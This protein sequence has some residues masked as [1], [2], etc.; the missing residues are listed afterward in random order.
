MKYI[1]S[2]R[3]NLLSC[4]QYRFNTISNIFLW[5]LSLFATF[6]F[7]IFAFREK[8]VINNYQLKD[9]LTFIILTKIVGTFTFHFIC[10]ELG[11]N[12]KSGKLSS[13]LVMPQNTFFYLYSRTA[14]AKIVEFGLA[15]FVFALFTPVLKNYF[16]LQSQPVYWLLFL[17]SILISS[18]LSFLVGILIGILAF[19]MQEIFAVIWSVLVLINFLSGQFIPLDFFPGR[20]ANVVEYL[21][22]AAFGYFPAKVFL[23]QVSINKILLHFMVYFIWALIIVLLIYILWRRG[24][25]KYEAVGA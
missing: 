2:V 8:S 11:D 17:L 19:W 7:W 16:I 25:K 15:V 23:G 3:V 1:Y 20:L 22:F 6:A 13:L 14:G 18:I 21:P 5:N 4:F 10:Y 9:M 24:L 12:I